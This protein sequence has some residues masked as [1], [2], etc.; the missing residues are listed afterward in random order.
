MTL[1]DERQGE[2]EE[3]GK[4]EAEGNEDGSIRYARSRNLASSFISCVPPFLA[5]PSLKAVLYASVSESCVFDSRISRRILPERAALTLA[6]KR[7]STCSSE[8]PLVSGTKL[9]GEEKRQLAARGGR[10]SR[11]R[12]TE[13]DAQEDE[14]GGEDRDAAP[15]EKHLGTETGRA[16]LVVDHVGRRVADAEVEEPVRGRRHRHLLAASRS[17]VDL[18]GDD[19]AVE[20]EEE[21][22]GQGQLPDEREGDEGEDE[23]T[24]DARDRAPGRGEEGDE[25]AHEGDEDL[26]AG[27]VRRGERSADDGDDEVADLRGRSVS[28]TSTRRASGA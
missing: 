22:E 23:E 18:A 4:S 15:D 28:A 13:R 11:P 27:L 8:R 1:C 24:M 14:E 16:G 3:T 6:R 26:L 2:E 10:T 7:M 9:R 25:D 17:R 21:E 20:E 19:P 12:G 5:P